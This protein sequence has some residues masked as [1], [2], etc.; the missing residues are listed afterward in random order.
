ML[1][2]STLQDAGRTVVIKTDKVPVVPKLMFQAEE[3]DD[4][5]LEKHQA[6]R[7][8]LHSVGGE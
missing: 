1:I 7:R 3:T 8:D 2:E 5:N 4:G 6:A